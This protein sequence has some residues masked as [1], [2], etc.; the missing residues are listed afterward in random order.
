MSR[1]LYVGWLETI[2]TRL[3]DWSSSVNKT[4]LYDS[5][6]FNPLLIQGNITLFNSLIFLS[7]N[8]VKKV[9]EQINNF[10]SRYYYALSA[11]TR[12]RNDSFNLYCHS[13]NFCSHLSIWC[14]FLFLYFNCWEEALQLPFHSR[15]LWL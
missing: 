8:I 9:Q 1:Q 4:K 13:I 6:F 11:C 15:N 3:F 12:L 2:R 7:I 5:K 10:A 14:T